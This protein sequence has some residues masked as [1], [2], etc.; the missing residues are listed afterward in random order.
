MIIPLVYGWCWWWVGIK[1]CIF[2]RG[3]ISTRCRVISVSE[4]N[5]WA[6]AVWLHS[7]INSVCSIFY[8]TILR[9]VKSPQELLLC[10]FHSK[11]RQ[12]RRW[13]F[14][15]WFRYLTVFCKWIPKDCNQNSS[16]MIYLSKAFLNKICFM[17][18]HQKFFIKGMTCIKSPQRLKYFNK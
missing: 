17:L 10:M 13:S 6:W 16:E 12:E 9:S 18:T 3:A 15:S 11:F 4:D 7:I 8:P 2:S 1:L 14:S 5:C